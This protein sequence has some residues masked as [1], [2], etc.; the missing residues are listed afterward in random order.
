MVSEKKRKQ[1][2][3]A[4]D[5]FQKK[6]FVFADWCAANQVQIVVGLV[7]VLLL[8][9]ANL[10]WKFYQAKQGEGRREELAVI[11]EAFNKELE[12]A[13]KESQS[14][15]TE[16]AGIDSKLKELAKSNTDTPESSELAEKKAELQKRIEAIKP[17]HEKTAKDYLGYFQKYAKAPE[18]LRAGLAALNIMVEKETFKEATEL[19]KDLLAQADSELDFYQ[20]QVRFLYLSLL[21]EQGLYIEALAETEKL[22][23]HANDDEMPKVLF[24]KARLEM[25]A[26][27]KSAATSTLDKLINEHNSSPEAQK[28][29]AMKYIW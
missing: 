10:S 18:G 28:A 22:M 24:A 11:D 4:P 29:K 14:L 2:L 8:V 7:S 19:A 17:K 15:Q 16:L 27:K 9:A 26:E 20:F 23:T 3:K 13:G 12:E 1:Q 6:A 5:E 25:L 21:E